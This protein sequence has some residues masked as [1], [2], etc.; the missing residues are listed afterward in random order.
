MSVSGIQQNDPVIFFFILFSIM[1][2]HRIWVSL[3]Y[4]VGP[5]FLEHSDLYFLFCDS[6]FLNC[7]TVLNK[8]VLLPLNLGICFA[9]Q[10]THTHTKNAPVSSDFKIS[11]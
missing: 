3:C 2:Y 5:C 6:V 1:A 4:T 7:A 9:K 8:N 10:D 11:I